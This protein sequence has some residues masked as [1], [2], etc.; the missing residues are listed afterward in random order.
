VLE[1]EDISPVAQPSVELVSHEPLVFTATIPLQPV[2]DI[3]DYQSMRR[4]KPEVNVTE[5]QVEEALKELQ[6]RY[7]TIEPVD[8]PAT[9]GD[10]VRADIKATADGMTVFSSNEIEFRLN[11]ASL[12]TLPGLANT[13]VGMSK[14]ESAETKE[15]VAE[16]FGDSRLAGKTVVYNVKLHEVKEEKLANLDDDFAREVGEGFE[17]LLALRARIREDIEKAESEAALR[18]YETEVVDALVEQ[19]SI[20]Y[21]PQMVEHE[22]DHVLEDQANLDPRDPRSQLLYLQRMN[23]SE[24]EVRDSVRP[25]AEQRIRRSLVLTEFAKAENIEVDASDIESEVESMASSSGEQ[26]E[27]VRQLFSSDQ[28]KDSLSRSLHTRKTLARLVEI[29]GQ[30]EEKKATTK[31]RRSGPRKESGE[32]DAPGATGD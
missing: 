8:R 3:G 20:E 29:T 4:P 9:E 16:D 32:D 6:T 17:T 7:G 27:M 31:R 11:E 1:Q 13:V 15:D 30:P 10:V 26:A 28:A 2:V 25:E 24:Q 12:S 14:G 5:E 18:N 19:A 21:A 23:L 22:I